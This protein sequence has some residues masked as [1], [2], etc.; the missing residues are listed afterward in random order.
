[1]RGPRSRRHHHGRWRVLARVERF[2]GH[3]VPHGIA[4]AHSLDD[5]ATDES[6]REDSP[7]DLAEPELR[8]VSGDREIT[9]EERPEAAAL[10]L[11]QA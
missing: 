3:R 5:D 2:A 7:V 10:I 1:M 6:A 11:E 8:L 4:H 9:G